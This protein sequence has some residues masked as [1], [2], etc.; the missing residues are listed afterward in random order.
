MNIAQFP[1]VQGQLTR[2]ASLAK[3]VWFRTG[4]EADWLLEPANLSD[5]SDFLKAMNNALPIMPLG[6]GSNLI[7]RDRGVEGLVIRLGKPFTNVE[8]LNNKQIKCGGGA[9]G[10]LVSSA[11]RN[12]GI[13]GLE[14]LR[15]IPGTVGGFVKM[16]GG[17]YGAEV[18]SILIECEVVLSNGDLETL[19]VSDL[20]YSY[21]RSSLPEQAVVVSA[22]F[23]GKPSDPKIITV[24]MD[25][26]ARAREETQPLR[27]KTGGSTFKNP[28][29]HLGAG[30]KAWELIDAAGCRGLMFGGAQVSEK[31]ANFLINLGSATST[32][33]ETLG[34]E[35]YSRVLESTG[36]N[37]EWEI[38]RVGRL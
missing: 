19:S 6:L 16:N 2:R 7:I 33:I 27:T 36:V 29:P 9:S 24:E 17:A 25:R 11:A 21:R 32:E 20:C 3:L 4:G 15:G 38:E 5:L 10:I 12:A 23:E 37:L 1:R 14:F 13:S 30:R 35:V 34:E 28:P 31:H 26:I 18:S 8:I 22:I